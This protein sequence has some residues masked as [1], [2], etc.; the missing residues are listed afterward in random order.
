MKTFDNEW[1]LQAF[2]DHPSFFTKRMFGGLAVYLF[3]RQMMVLVEPTKTGRWKWHGVLICTEHEH[4]PAIVE[5][6]P[7]LAPHDILKKWLYIDSR[8]AD[9]EPTMERVAKPSPRT[10]RDSGSIL[11]RGRKES[12]HGGAVRNRNT[13][14]RSRMRSLRVTFLSWCVALVLAG[15]GALHFYWALGGRWAIAVSVQTRGVRCFSRGSSRP[16]WSP[17]YCSGLPFW[18]CRAQLPRLLAPEKLTSWG[19]WVVAVAFLARAMGEFR[20][21]GFFKRVRGTQFADLDTRVYSPLCLALG[22][23]TAAVALGG[24]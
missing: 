13:A 7:Q 17:R 4:H 24:G 3:G 8:H 9:F 6:F 15:L 18:C 12:G 20:Y 22:L 23:A 16:S 5:E 2:E 19:R 10:T 1:A 14:T 11:T 21:V